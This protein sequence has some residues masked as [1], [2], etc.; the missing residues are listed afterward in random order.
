MF[1]ESPDIDIKKGGQTA[2]LSLIRTHL[3]AQLVACPYPS[4]PWALVMCICI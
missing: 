1:P 2:G 3:S 4:L